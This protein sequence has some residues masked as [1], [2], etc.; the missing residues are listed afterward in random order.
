MPPQTSTCPMWLRT[1]LWSS[2][3][4]PELRSL[5][6]DYSWLSKGQTLSSCASLA[7][8]HSTHFWTFSQTCHTWSHCILRR[9]MCSVREPQW[10]SAPVSFSLYTIDHTD[11]SDLKDTDVLG[12]ICYY[13]YYFYS[14]C[15][16]ALPMRNAPRFT[17]DVTDTSIVISWNPVPRV[18]YR[19][20]FRLFAI[21]F[22]LYCAY[23]VCEFFPKIAVN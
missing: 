19:V 8:W 5:V 21:C 18:G 10:P 11:G 7:A 6:T 20:H 2:G 16:V 13:P 23:T 4:L 17:T 12:R 22:T 9:A 1:V 14:L 15:I 3:Q